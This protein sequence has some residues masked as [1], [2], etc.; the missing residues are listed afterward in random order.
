MPQTVH[1]YVFDGFADW[2]AAFAVAGIQQP[3]FQRRPGQW[4][5]RTVGPWRHAPVRSAGGLTVVPDLGLD[6]IRP[7]DSAMLILP[8][9]DGW[10]DNDSAHMWAINKAGDFLDQGV[11]VAAI[12]GATAGLA[13]AGLLDDRNHTSNAQA[14]LN[15]T[16]Y[17]GSA[18]YRNEPVV[19]GSGLITAGGMAPLEFAR[20]I[21]S[22]LG[23]YD[24][25][26]LEAWYQLYKTGQPAWYARM[27]QA[28]EG[29]E[30]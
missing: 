11:P 28:A 23:I 7:A 12:C 26:V 24:D 8:G 2:E 4:Q 27:Q 30:V 18:F 19:V 17:D 6:Q 29:A 15:G 1:L 22:E 20:A 25:D 14:Y 3:K 9:G 21:F 10:E 16:G 5:V 13:K